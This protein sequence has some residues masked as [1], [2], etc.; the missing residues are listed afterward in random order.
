MERIAENVGII[1][2]FFCGAFISKNWQRLK[3][4][5]PFTGEKAT[6]KGG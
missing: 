2:A 3:N 1:I 5:L 4:V 6:S